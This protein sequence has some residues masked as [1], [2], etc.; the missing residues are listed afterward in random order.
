MKIA[1][2]TAEGVLN[3]HFGH[4]KSFT[5]VEVDPQTRKIIHTSEIPAPRHEPGVLPRFLGELGV[6]VIIAGGMGMQAQNLFDGQGITV[7]IGAPSKTPMELV[8]EYLS[9][10]LVSGDNVCDH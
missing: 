3:M 7:V 4:C 5:L 9:G 1:I 8:T 6:D 10:T 2:P